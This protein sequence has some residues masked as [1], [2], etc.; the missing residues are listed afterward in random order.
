LLKSQ[1]PSLQNSVTNMSLDVGCY[2]PQEHEAYYSN[3]VEECIDRVPSCNCNSL[4]KFSCF[5]H[6]FLSYKWNIWFDHFEYWPI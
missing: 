4:P 3:Q 6:E 5:I 2:F 1:A